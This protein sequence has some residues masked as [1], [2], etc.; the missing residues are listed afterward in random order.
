MSIVVNSVGRLHR[1]FVKPKQADRIAD[2]LV[3]LLPEYGRVLDVGCGSYP[4]FLT[5]ADFEEKY[6]LDKNI[7]TTVMK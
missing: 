3:E 6:G 1:R 4:M 7:D 5:M 2:I